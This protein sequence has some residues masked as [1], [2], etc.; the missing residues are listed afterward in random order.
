MKPQGSTEHSLANTALYTTNQK[1][2]NKVLL[3]SLEVKV[4]N[5]NLKWPDPMTLYLSSIIH[6]VSSLARTNACAR[7][8]A[9]GSQVARHGAEP[10][11]Q[12]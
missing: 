7:H 8:G 1:L 2:T 5:L 9:A 10:S 11:T 3:T 6:C 12:V 4:T